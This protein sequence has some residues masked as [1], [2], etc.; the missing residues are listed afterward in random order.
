MDGVL[1]SLLL[2]FKEVLFV[3]LAHLSRRLTGELIVKAGIC[4]P[5]HPFVRRATCSN[6]FSS[7]TVWLIE[8]YF[9]VKLPWSEGTNFCSR[10][11]GHN[12]K[13]AVT[14]IYGKSPSKIFFCRTSRPIALELGILHPINT[15]TT[16]FQADYKAVSETCNFWRNY[17]DVADSWDSIR[18]IIEFY[19][20]DV[21]NFSS[22]AKPGA[23]NDPD[24]V[25]TRTC[26]CLLYKL[27]LK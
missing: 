13:I 27:C 23:W 11:L 24:M 7:K 5:S 17:D 15:S 18:N 26:T 20:E 25:C 21:G 10:D 19:G 2:C 4:R 9:H 16:L 22:A 6:M 8:T 14:P 12:T 3:I 1:R